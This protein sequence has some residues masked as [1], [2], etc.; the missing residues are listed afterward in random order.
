MKT[1]PSESV[2]DASEFVSLR[3][4]KSQPSIRS[5]FHTKTPSSESVEDAS[6]FMSLRRGMSQP[7]IRSQFHTKTFP[8]ESVDNASE[9]VS[10]RRIPRKLILVAEAKMDD[11]WANLHLCTAIC[12]I[13]T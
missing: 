5:Q 1:P 3:R 7:S 10:L 4:G 11:K 2:E 9:S 8:T 6:E 13:L 12:S